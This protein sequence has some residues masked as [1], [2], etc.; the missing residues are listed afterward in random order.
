MLSWVEE[1]VGGW[2]V[3]CEVVEGVTVTRCDGGNEGRCVPGLAR[4]LR[5]LN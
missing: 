1:V 3:E 4:G 5:S 2:F